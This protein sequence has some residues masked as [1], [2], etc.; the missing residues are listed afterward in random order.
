MNQSRET[1]YS[2]LFALVSSATTFKVASRRVRLLNEVEPSLLPAL[3]MQ[4]V[5]ETAIA[6]RTTPGKYTLRVDL[7]VYALADDASPSAA[8][9]LNTLVDAVEA[10]LVAQPQTLGGLVSH[11]SVAGEIVFFEGT[12]SNRAGAIIPVEIVTT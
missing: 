4:Q 5:S 1:L 9:Q 2:A 8:P 6:S 7:A 10:A 3:F 12:L 11:C